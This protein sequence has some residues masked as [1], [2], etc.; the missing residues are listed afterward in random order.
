[1]NRLPLALAIAI[2]IAIAV[3]IDPS[4]AAAQESGT[5]SGRVVGAA[6][7]APVPAAAVRILGTVI[8]TFT[9]DSG[10]F[11]LRDVPAGR[12]RLAVERIGYGPRQLEV[13]VRAGAVAEVEVTL[14][15]RAVALSGVVA[16]VTKRELGLSNA[17]VSVSVMDVSEV[18]QRV[19]ATAAD[20]V[21]YAPSVQF[22]GEQVNIRG[23]SGYGR[24]TGSRVLLLV[25]G[26]PANAGDSGNLNWDVIPLTEVERVEVVKS[27]SSALYGTSALGGVINVVTA[28]PPAE[29]ITRVRLRGGFYDDPPHSEWIWSS[30]TLGYASAELSHGRQ[31][32]PLTLWLRGGRGIDDGYQQN[33]DL[34]RANVALRLGLSGAADDLVLFGSWAQEKHGESLL[35]CMRG[36]CP[37]PRRLEFQPLRVPV[38]AQDDRTRSDKARSYVTHQRRWSDR[39]STFERLSLSWNDWETDFGDSL[40]GA[41]TLVWGGELKFDWQAANWLFLTLGSE[42]AYT[43]VNADLFGQ[44]DLTDLSLYGQG[45][46]GVTRWLT[47]TA[48]LR[49]D[50]R[51]IDG[52]SL[53]DPWSSE[54]SPRAGLVLAPDARTRLR[55]SL[56]KGFRAPSAAELFTATEVGGFLVIPNPDLEPERSLAGELGIQRLV[57][58]WL[59]F[60]VAGFFY[61]FED[62]IVADTVVSAEGIEIQFD[63]L[64]EARILGLEAIAR[65]S[66][67]RDRLQLQGS[68]TY[69]DTED[70]A[71]SEPLPYRPRHLLTAAGSLYLGGL[72]IGADYR[73]ASAFERVQVFTDERT[74]PR[75]DMRVLDARLA[76]RIGRQTIRFTVDNAANYGYT[77][78]ERNLEPIRRYT[79]ALELEF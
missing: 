22:V 58:S 20:A 26:V 73:I 4:S 10:R 61:E 28:K 18:M 49:G 57:T 19:P 40:I 8:S 46:L 5:V 33:G 45:E 71:T 37:D 66:F 24:G 55:A 60:D 70:K 12:R 27:A 76:Y 75:V 1:M 69:L 43:D 50:V 17:P 35:W 51:L 38:D 32:G 41:E 44:H 78:I 3:A 6:T 52:G 23:S 29:P 63:N 67:I 48:G 79:V 7:G 53:S 11:E 64:P 54:L 21:A 62:L 47:L 39:V 15:P 59:A 74:D 65:F 14:R 34:D 9:D 2:A 77:T 16:S 68:Y 31:L 42:G 13:E 36:Q 56:G 72:E 30:Q 25:D